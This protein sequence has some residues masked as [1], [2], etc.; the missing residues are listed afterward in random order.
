MSEENIVPVTTLPLRPMLSFTDPAEEIDFV[1]YYNNYYYHYAQV[2]LAMGLVLIFGDFLADFLAFPNA[3]E[4]NYRVELCIPLLL[5]GLACSFSP[6]VRKHWQPAM[7]AYIALIAFS[8]FWVLV[9]IDR[10]GGMGIRSWVGILNFVFLEFYCFVILG[11]QFNY[12]FVSGA[13]ILLAFESI[14]AL[15]FGPDWRM[16]G[17]WSYHVV[18]S[19][20]LAVVIGWWREFVLRK[21]F[22]AKTALE[23][24][25]RNAERLT[26]VKSDF[27]AT[28]SHEIRS[29]LSGLLG[30]IDLLRES[31]LAPEQ[32]QMARIAHDSA[33]S[34]LAVL[35]DILNFS[36]V[37]AAA[38][39]IAP[40]PVGLR[41]LLGAVA[42]PHK[43]QAA[44]KG[45]E[46]MV[47]F[48]PE[49]P[50]CVSVDPLRLRQIVNNLL[51][52][53]V[54]FT[55]AGRIHLNV[56]R[57]PTE[58][59][60]RMRFTV[61]DSGIGMTEA[62][63]DRLF[64]P[65]VQADAS[66]TRDFGGTGLGL[67]ISSRLAQL[68]GGTLEA[69][70]VLGQGSVFVLRLPLRPAEAADIAEE[71]DA[72]PEP[73]VMA[74]GLKLL[75]VDDDASIRWLTMRQLERLGVSAEAAENGETALQMLRASQFDL[76][77][78]DCHMARM[79]G[80]ALTRA[81]RADP[82]PRLRGLPIVGLTAD[83]TE[84]QRERALQAGMVEVAI[85][86]LSRWQ[87]SH[88]LARCLPSGS[89]SKPLESSTPARQPVAFDEESCK[90]A[91]TGDDPR[92]APALS[93]R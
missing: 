58:S 56:E 69:T 14:L 28:M 16:F 55:F 48:D 32:L 21:D 62:V 13:I 35:N 49:M 57:D 42:E 92:A 19:F 71:R 73:V 41:N 11:V 12:A 25:R 70:S 3:S 54:K 29:P 22:S 93:D 82:D 44:R 50:D 17:Y 33:T 23:A 79:D 4:N 39:S 9:V 6:S 37:E 61:R 10:Q 74:E 65:F 89:A 76:V 59:I 51:S 86:P 63:L 31:R 53:A 36:K 18:T 85:K 34:L 66:T 8:L 27:L 46:L 60:A 24:A 72:E 2:S 43:L 5:L 75:V 47:R 15:V 7:A 68:L 91:F 77:L 88:L 80:I 87:L 84:R 83:V 40:E 45:V 52:N 81:I 38:L 64:E 78:T 30:V 20:V 67:S 90:D 26:R 1:R